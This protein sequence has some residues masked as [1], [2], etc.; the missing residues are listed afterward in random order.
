MP[1]TLWPVALA[2]LLGL[3]HAATPYTVGVIVS[4]E[5]TA[6]VAGDAQ[7]LAAIAFASR[8]RAAGGIFG[9]PFQVEVR[10][11]E[12]IPSKALEEAK[13]LIGNGVDALVCCTVPAASTR[14]AELAETSDVPL[15]SPTVL[16]G[17]DARPYWSFSLAPRDE[18]ALAAVVADA[19]AR[20]D[21]SV[22]LM[23][24][25]NG[26]GDA[27]LTD[28]KALLKVAGL[29][30]AGDAR[31]PPGSTDLTP[32]GLWIATRQPDAV[33]IWGL[34]SDLTVALDGLRR[35]GYLGPVYA[36]TALLRA[37]EGGLDM[38]KLDGV[39][40]AVPPITV[41]S[42]LSSGATCAAAARTA[43][44][45]LRAVYGGVID[46]TY[47]APVYDALDLLKQAFVQVA[48]LRLPSGELTQRRQATRD[49]LIGL[50]PTCG[51]GGLYDLREGQRPALL[52][53]GLAI[54][55]V[56]EG[57]LVAA[58]APTP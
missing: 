46:L 40:F 15:L 26:F 8:L 51:A 39:L 54:A 7:S 37:V 13:T 19:Q 17:V 20:G 52:P 32:Q 28:L 12:G 25:D 6:R 57:R 45:R 16:Q 31:Y 38:T 1:R 18:D 53:K 3:A 47:A 43:S 48:A 23:T 49:S 11:D 4:K 29:T 24:L 2:L 44:S 22:A 21:R 33:V 55:Q 50:P 41:A 14:V 58:P 35:R 42:G 56:R 9:T 30:F 5:G 10:D 27:A 36:R 34:K